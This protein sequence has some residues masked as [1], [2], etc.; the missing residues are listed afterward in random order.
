MGKNSSC[1]FALRKF[2]FKINFAYIVAFRKHRTRVNEEAA[3]EASKAK[4]L[5]KKINLEINLS[6]FYYLKPDSF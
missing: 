3:N 1:A 5:A 4:A 6:V 2:I